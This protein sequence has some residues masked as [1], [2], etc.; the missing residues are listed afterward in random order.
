MRQPPTIPIVRRR[1]N[2]G[3]PPRQ[4]GAACW[5]PANSAPSLDEKEKREGIQPPLP[6]RRRTG[7]RRL[8]AAFVAEVGDP[9]TSR[10]APWFVK[11]AAA[12]RGL[13]LLLLPLVDRR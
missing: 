6:L 2:A 11:G 5:N 9:A 7:H 3:S 10:D 1:P 4:E 8:A 13:R 12:E